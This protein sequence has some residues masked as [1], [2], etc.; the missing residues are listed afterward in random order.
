MR[1]L[2]EEVTTPDY[3][4]QL[5]VMQTQLEML[6]AAVRELIVLLGGRKDGET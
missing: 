4:F 1:D 3:R 6:T 5:A 2:N